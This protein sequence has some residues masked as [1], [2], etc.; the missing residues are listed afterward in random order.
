M[1]P[2]PAPKVSP[3]ESSR[4]HSKF[5][6]VLQT[7]SGDVSKSRSI[8]R[9]SIWAIRGEIPAHADPIC[10]LPS[11]LVEIPL[12]EILRKLM[13]LDSDINTDFD[14]N[15]PY[16][17]GVISETIKDPIDHIFRKHQNQIA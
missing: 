17:E 6:P 13:D 8:N 4:P 11:K 12:Q 2:K 7:R 15:S 5:I 3:S 1:Q 14:E 10:R 16:Q 9:V